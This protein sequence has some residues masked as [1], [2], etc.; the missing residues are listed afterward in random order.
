M[1][2]NSKKSAI[3]ASQSLF[4]ARLAYSVVLIL[5]LLVTGYDVWRISASPRH[6]ST[7]IDVRIAQDIHDDLAKLE[8]RAKDLELRQQKDNAKVFDSADV[9]QAFVIVHAEVDALD[10]PEAREKM[11]ALSDN[12]QRWAI[13]IDQIEKKQNLA[14]SSTP[15]PTPLEFNLQIPILI[16]HKTPDRFDDILTRLRQKGYSTVTLDEVETALRSRRP[17]AGKPLVITF[18][19]GFT[20]QLAAFAALKKHNMKAVFYIISGGDASH[21]CIGAN[22]T[23]TSCGDNYLTW[24]QIRQLDQSGLIEIGGHTVDHLS[25]PSVQSSLLQFE[26]TQ[27]KTEIETQLG[28]PIRH[29]AYPYGSYNQSV[30]NA[31]RNAGY[32]SAVSTHFGVNQTVSQLY[33]MPRVRDADKLP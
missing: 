3:T 24:D 4:L 13:T 27:N 11:R 17:I 32:S 8:Q 5:L 20:D 28:H 19:D 9:A 26:I 10:Y 7:G 25:L 16:Y 33:S 31:V 18:D 30:I 2:H 23:N 6:E 12:L 29:F 1:P 22:R 21:Y 14:S 15:R